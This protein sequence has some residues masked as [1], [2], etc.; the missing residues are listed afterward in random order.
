MIYGVQVLHEDYEYRVSNDSMMR[1]ADRLYCIVNHAEGFW[2]EAKQ[3]ELRQEYID[4]VNSISRLHVPTESASAND[5]I[6]CLDGDE[7]ISDPDLLR[8]TLGSLYED[9]VAVAMPFVNLWDEGCR[10]RHLADGFVDYR[11]HC[12]RPRSWHKIDRTMS[13][14]HSPN[15]IT[16]EGRIYEFQLHECA[17]IHYGN[18]DKAERERKIGERRALDPNAKAWGVD[19][20][21]WL[22]DKYVEPIPHCLRHMVKD[23]K[24]APKRFECSRLLQT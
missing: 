23:V 24:L 18:R 11:V 16:G 14:S 17:V 8:K 6:V 4:G 13:P 9:H 3:W 21:T 20:D 2:R 22:S 12:W 1:V 15:G 7:Q 5:W 10:Y 19:F